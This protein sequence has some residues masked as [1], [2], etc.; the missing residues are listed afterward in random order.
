LEAYYHFSEKWV[1]TNYVGVDR[2]IANNATKLNTTTQRPKDQ[3]GISFATGF[4][5]YINKNTGLYIR[6]RWFTNSD[7]NFSLDRYKGMETTV[8]LKIYF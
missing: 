6:Q 4:D 3:T 8:E 7:K 1:F 5:Y 2:I